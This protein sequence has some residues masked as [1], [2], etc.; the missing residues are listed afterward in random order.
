M[1]DEVYDAYREAGGALARKVLRRGGAGGL[2]KEGGA[3]LL[4]MVEETENMVAEQG[5]LLAFPLNVSFNEAAA[6]DTAMP[7]D[8]RIFSRG[9]TSSRSISGSMSTATSPTPP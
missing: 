5:A 1:D 6:H 8:E 9:A 3:A 2:V 7:G 4:D